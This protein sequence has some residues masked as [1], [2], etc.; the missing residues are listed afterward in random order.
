LS[1]KERAEPVLE[2]RHIGEILDACNGEI[3]LRGK[4]LDDIALAREAKLNEQGFEPLVSRDSSRSS[5][6]ACTL[7]TRSRAGSS[8]F[9]PSTKRAA[10]NRSTALRSTPFASIDDPDFT[11]PRR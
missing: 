9:P 4:R 11:Q 2:H 7:S 10:S 5:L 8:S 6:P 3:E 1:Q